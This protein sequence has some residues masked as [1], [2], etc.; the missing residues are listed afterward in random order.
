MSSTRSSYFPIQ[1]GLEHFPG[2]IKYTLK[3]EII[4]DMRGNSP[5]V[6]RELQLALWRDMRGH[7]APLAQTGGSQTAGHLIPALLS[8]SVFTPSPETSLVPFNYLSKSSPR[9]WQDFSSLTPCC[10]EMAQT[11]LGWG[12]RGS[13]SF[14]PHPTHHRP[15]GHLWGVGGHH[16][17]V[18]S[19]SL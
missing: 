8:A 17:A 18:S 13:C 7:R 10:A 14:P 11:V 16:R 3:E 2:W 9:E 15:G 12:Q 5:F 4:T 1:I 6:H 19:Q